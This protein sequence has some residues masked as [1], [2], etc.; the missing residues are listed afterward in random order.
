MSNI[1]NARALVT[2]G[3]GFIGSHLVEA[4]VNRGAS[5]VVV[6]DDL[7]LGRRDNL[8]EI[9]NDPRVEICEL[10]ASVEESMADLLRR[11]EPDFVFNLAVVPLPASL[12][13]PRWSAEVNIN[14]TLAL[15][16]LQRQGL[17]DRLVHY[18]SSEAYGT[19]IHVPMDEDH[20]L[21]PHTPYAAS[22][23]AGDHLATAYSLTFDHPFMTIRP[24]NNYGPRQ[25]MLQYAGIVPTAIRSI[26][27]EEPVVVFG[28]GLQTRDYIFVRD[29]VEATLRLVETDEAWGQTINVASGAELSVLTLITMLAEICGKTLTI[30]HL[31]P[32]PGDVRR[33]VADVTRATR[34]L[35]GPVAKTLLTQGLEETVRWYRDYYAHHDA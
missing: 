7:F 1:R 24:F 31:P 5:R 28:D 34:L 22:K 13:R 4:I 18:S 2:G 19:A 32:R 10:D 6:V 21:V 35:G 27:R 14:L 11:V 30:R 20:P 16:E 8:D 12:T 23:A 17:F 26:L 33:H 29:T 25:N 9:A 15:C 3:A